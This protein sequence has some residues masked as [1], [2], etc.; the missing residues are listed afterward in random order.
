MAPLKGKN[1][2]FKKAQ[3][4]KVLDNPGQFNMIPKIGPILMI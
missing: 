2:T 4:V 3:Q 1:W